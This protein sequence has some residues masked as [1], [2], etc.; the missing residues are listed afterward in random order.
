MDVHTHG[1]PGLAHGIDQK[2]LHIAAEALDAAFATAS[3]AAS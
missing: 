2:G 3:M 1:R